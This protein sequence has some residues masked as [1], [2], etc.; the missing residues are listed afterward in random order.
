[1]EQLCLTIQTKEYLE[2]ESEK[3]RQM[4]KNSAKE[5]QERNDEECVGSSSAGVAEQSDPTNVG[6]KQEVETPIELPDNDLG[7]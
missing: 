5:F 4:L 3:L 1:M 2:K 6:A 7:R